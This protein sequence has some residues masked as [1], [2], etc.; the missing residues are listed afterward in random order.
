MKNNERSIDYVCD[1]IALAYLIHL[2]ATWRKPV[3]RYE[4][5]D[6]EVSQSFL[7]GMVHGYPKDRMNSDY[8]LK[9][10]WKLLKPKR[11]NPS[12]S[13]I[14][15]GGSCPELTPRGIKYMNGLMH[16]YGD[17]LSSIGVAQPDGTLDLP[18]S[19]Y[20]QNPA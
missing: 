9:F 19:F 3:Y 8:R 16:K 7:S 5:G 14:I 4:A 1:V 17:M 10:Y 20:Q 11:V 18:S 15:N 12:K 6:I 2:T 13:V